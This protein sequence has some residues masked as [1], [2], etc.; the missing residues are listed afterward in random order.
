MSEQDSDVGCWAVLPFQQRPTAKWSVL[1]FT[2][3]S[4]LIPGSSGLPEGTRKDGG[5]RHPWRSRVGNMHLSGTWELRI[6]GMR[7]LCLDRLRANLEI[8][9]A[10][11]QKWHRLPAS[12][13]WA[14][15][16]FSGYLSFSKPTTH[17]DSKSVQKNL[18]K[19]NCSES[20]CFNCLHS[21]D[22]GTAPPLSQ[23]S[24]QP[25]IWCHSMDNY[26]VRLC[27]RQCI[28]ILIPVA[29]PKHGAWFNLETEMNTY[30]RSSEQQRLQDISLRRAVQSNLGWACVSEHGIA[31]TMHDVS[32]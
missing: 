21:V 8:H 11:H 12:A 7:Q 32:I 31:G 9:G 3:E 20:N 25:S 27:T 10:W 1:L 5:P 28:G 30:N 22:C 18:L 23:P 15:S 6:S 17:V 29:S 4:T 26:W 14:P 13:P 24:A 2:P 16:Q 19:R